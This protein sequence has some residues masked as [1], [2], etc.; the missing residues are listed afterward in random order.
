MMKRICCFV[1]LIMISIGIFYSCAQLPLNTQVLNDNAS[2]MI[3]KTFYDQNYTYGAYY[4]DY[5]DGKTKL[6]DASYPKERTFLITS[7]QDYERIFGSKADLNIDFSSEMLAVYTFT[8]QYVREIRI[9][10]VLVDGQKLYINLSMIKPRRAVAD[11]VRPYQR[12]VVI[13]LEKV[14]VSEVEINID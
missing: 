11:A 1:L 9:D 5:E 13:K 2:E 10:E 7:R 8:A 6:D 12:Y 4:N 3:D 14:D